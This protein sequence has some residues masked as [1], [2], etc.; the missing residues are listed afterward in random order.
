M[1]WVKRKIWVLSHR[2]LRLMG[3]LPLMGVEI[4]VK[5]H[6]DLSFAG[7]K[8]T[9]CPFRDDVPW[10][11]WVFCAVHKETGTLLYLYRHEVI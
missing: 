10:Q 7:K 4:T 3:Y 1:K 11:P 5:N 9:V 6:P 8:A 2:F